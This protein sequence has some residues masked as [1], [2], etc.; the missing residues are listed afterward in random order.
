MLQLCTK[1][2]QKI[3]MGPACRCE[4]TACTPH[5][6]ML[7]CRP[8]VAAGATAWVWGH[9]RTDPAM[10]GAEGSLQLWRSENSASSSSVSCTTLRYKGSAATTLRMHTVGTQVLQPYCCLSLHTKALHP[11]CSVC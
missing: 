6:E 7:A 5:L 4:H 11:F 1:E 8:F 2:A 10:Q 9:L 3:T